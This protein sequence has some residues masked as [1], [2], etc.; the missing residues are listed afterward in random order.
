ML[1]ALWIYCW[2][3][4]YSPL[5]YT[6]ISI[7]LFSLRL[8]LWLNVWTVLEEVP[9]GTKETVS[10]WYLGGICFRF[11]EV[12]L[13][14]GVLASSVSKFSSCSGDLSTGEYWVL[15]LLTSTVWRINLLCHIVN[16]LMKFGVSHEYSFRIIMHSW[17]IVLLKSMK[18]S[19]SLF[20]TGLK[21]LL[22]NT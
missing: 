15:K 12:Y 18:Q 19:S 10:L 20:L 22:S 4:C 17:C 5:F 2:D 7:F 9:W 1:V 21:S 6:I 3:L 8:A 11:C 14:C 16:I 13:T